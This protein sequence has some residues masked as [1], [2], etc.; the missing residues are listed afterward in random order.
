MVG[1]DPTSDAV[2]MNW[3]SAATF[4][5]VIPDELVGAMWVFIVLGT[6]LALTLFG[7]ALVALRTIGVNAE[8]TD[9]RSAERGSSAC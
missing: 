5:F 8:R 7:T 4:P 6:A 1:A 3:S 2:A 9:R